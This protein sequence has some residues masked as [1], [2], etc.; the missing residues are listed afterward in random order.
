[1][2]V[3]ALPIGARTIGLDPRITANGSYTLPQ[4]AFIPHPSLQQLSSGMVG[5]PQPGIISAGFAAPIGIDSR[6][7]PT[8]IGAV[9][10]IRA[11]NYKQSP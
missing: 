3:N 7:Y 6:A 4:Y 2:S 11:L 10:G 5:A 9:Y 8:P 1:M